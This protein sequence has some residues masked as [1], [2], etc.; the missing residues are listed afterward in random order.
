MAKVD[1]SPNLSCTGG[2][3]IG[4]PTAITITMGGSGYEYNNGGTMLDTACVEITEISPFRTTLTNPGWTNSIAGPNSNDGSAKIKSG[5]LTI[6][7]PPP[8]TNGTDT[9][10]MTAVESATGAKVK[11]KFKSSDS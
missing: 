11:V 2:V 5:V 4:S 1:I 9:W 6:N 10:T 7:A 3:F 8:G